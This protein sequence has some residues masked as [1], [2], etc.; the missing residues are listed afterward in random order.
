MKNLL[1]HGI[2]NKCSTKGGGD[3]LNILTP[4]ILLEKYLIL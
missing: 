1:Q 3:Y 4:N 2:L